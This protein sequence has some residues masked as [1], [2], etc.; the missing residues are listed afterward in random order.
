M[1]LPAPLKEPIVALI[2]DK[3]YVSLV[4]DFDLTDVPCIKYAISKALGFGIVLGGSIVKIPQIL[5]IVS[6]GSARGLSLTSYILET[7]SCCITFSYNWR[8][9]NPFSTYGE[10]CFLTAQN[11]II[12]LLILFYAQR[13]SETTL[14]LVGYAAVL[15]GLTCVVPSWVMASLYAA[16]IPL[17]LA[18]K[19][20]QIYTNFANKSTGQLSVFA[21]V[22]YFAGTTARVFTTMTELDDPLMLTGS[23]LASVLNGILMIQVFL[24]W[25]K[26]LEE[27][28]PRKVE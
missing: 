12:T 2:G 23:V 20:P 8:Q 1:L 9:G 25:G 16:T 19:V 10:T 21:V 26:K 6:A 7:L 24:Y 3:C 28:K 5:T 11:I 15:Y 14:T 22:N 4:E 13:L 17:S 18:S 27:E